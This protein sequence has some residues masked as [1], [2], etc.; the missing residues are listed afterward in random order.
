MNLLEQILE[1]GYDK[2][3]GDTNIYKGEAF[4]ETD[5]THN[6]SYILD[7]YYILRTENIHIHEGDNS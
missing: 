5:V 2:T 3:V 7:A 1:R 4:R 6:V